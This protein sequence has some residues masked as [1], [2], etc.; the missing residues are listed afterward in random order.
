MKHVTQ[1]DFAERIPV[2]RQETEMV[3]WILV[4]LLAFVTAAAFYLLL[5]RVGGTEE[6]ILFRVEASNAC[7]AHEKQG[8]T[9]AEV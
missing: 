7:A 6:R 2:N 4:V 8:L 9:I 1:E 5:L 3:A